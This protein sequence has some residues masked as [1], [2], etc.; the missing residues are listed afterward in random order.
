MAHGAQGGTLV[1]Y[2]LEIAKCPCGKLARYYAYTAQN[3]SMGLYCTVCARR[4]VKE[5]GEYEVLR[6]ETENQEAE[7]VD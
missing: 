3:D 4:K 6:Y 2:M 1:A 5:R 7:K